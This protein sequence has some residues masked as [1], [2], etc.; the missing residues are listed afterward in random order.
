[1]TE[2]IAILILIALVILGVSIGLIYG[3]RRL[4]DSCR[5]INNRRKF[6]GFTASDA[7]SQHSPSVMQRKQRLHS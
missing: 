3:G 7:C 6:I 1:M 2:F 4:K 5:G